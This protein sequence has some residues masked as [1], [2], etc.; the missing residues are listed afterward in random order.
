MKTWYATGPLA[1]QPPA[2][3]TVVAIGQP[4]PAAEPPRAPAEQPV[5]V[6]GEASPVLD[7]AGVTVAGEPIE[8]GAPARAVPSATPVD[9]LAVFLADLELSSA[10]P[11]LQSNDVR[12]V[13]DLGLLND[14]DLK[15]LGLTLGARRKILDALKRLEAPRGGPSAAAGR[16]VRVS[17]G[18]LSEESAPPA[19][20]ASSSDALRAYPKI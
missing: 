9:D 16:Q 10:L 14:E 18:G 5:L 12:T 6:A 1:L 8:L 11:T 3:P 17:S 20:T 15:E 13:A 19:Y 7:P 2:V 4:V